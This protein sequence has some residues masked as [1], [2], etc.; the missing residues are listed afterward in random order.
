MDGHEISN[1]SFDVCDGWGVSECEEM[2]VNDM[3]EARL[4]ID[5]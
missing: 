4:S 3:V 1:V 5:S 2:G